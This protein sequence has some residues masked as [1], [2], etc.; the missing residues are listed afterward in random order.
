M[1]HSWLRS[2][3]SLP[4][5]G[6]LTVFKNSSF[7]PLPLKSRFFET[8]VWIEAANVFALIFHVS[9]GTTQADGDMTVRLHNP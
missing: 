7:L 5:S 6:L 9:K 2:I 4:F 1:R 8:K 3:L